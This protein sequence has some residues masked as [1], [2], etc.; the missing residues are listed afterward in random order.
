[1]GQT[2]NG[3]LEPDLVLLIT[4]TNEDQTSACF[5]R[6]PETLENKPGGQ[7]VQVDDPVAAVRAKWAWLCVM[8]LRLMSTDHQEMLLTTI[9]ARRLQRISVRCHRRQNKVMLKLKLS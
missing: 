2:R 3:L 5:L 7:K 9:E 1:M 6:A 8:R 4:S